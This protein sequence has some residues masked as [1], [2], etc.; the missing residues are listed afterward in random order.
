MGSAIHKSEGFYFR[1]DSRK[2]PQFDRHM[3][4]Q[5]KLNAENKRL[6]AQSLTINDT[7]DQLIRRIS[8][9]MCLQWKTVNK[10]FSDINKDESKAI[11]KD[12]LAYYLKFWG[13]QFTDD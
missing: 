11:E 10:A 9:K 8:N 13:Y 6:A 7:K 4:I 5:T 3:E 12:E 1:H 2:N